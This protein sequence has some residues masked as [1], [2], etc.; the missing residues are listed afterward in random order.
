M[1]IYPAYH[2]VP[3]P[4]MVFFTNSSKEQ[5]DTIAAEIHKSYGI[6]LEDIV[7]LNGLVPGTDVSVFVEARH[8]PIA[9]ELKQ[10][11]AAMLEYFKERTSG[12]MEW[13]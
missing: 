2:P 5:E 13:D 1:A 10:F 3:P 9:D 6:P 11:V 8:K 7:V 12:P 4:G